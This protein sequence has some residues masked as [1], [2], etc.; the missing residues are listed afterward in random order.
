MYSG[1]KFFM[2]GVSGALRAE[3][4]AHNIKVTCIQPGDV[5]TE[6]LNRT[7][8]FEVKLMFI[9]DSYLTVLNLSTHCISKQLCI[10]MKISQ[11]F[12]VK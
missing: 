2:E 7:S 12:I 1:T 8:D 9:Y 5:K 11:L 3:M 6:L 4:T 10:F